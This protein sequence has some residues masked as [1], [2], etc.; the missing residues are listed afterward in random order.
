MNISGTAPDNNI[1]MVELPTEKQREKNILF[2]Q[3]IKDQGAQRGRRSRSDVSGRVTLTE[4]STSDVVRSSQR[5]ATIYPL[6][7]LNLVR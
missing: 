2:V 3:F 4:L 1:A 6:K 5:H 7:V